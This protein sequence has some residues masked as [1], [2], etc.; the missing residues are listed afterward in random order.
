MREL[1]LAAELYGTATQVYFNYKTEQLTADDIANMK[2]AASAVSIPA[3]CDEITSGQLPDG[4]SKRTR[5]VLFEADNS[6]RQYFYFD[7]AN[8]SKY[9]FMLN[10]NV[11]TP[12]QNTTGD[13][14]Y[15]EQTNIASG[16][17]SR[18]YT[19]S[20]SDGVNTFQTRSSAL[21]YAYN[22]QENSP[23]PDMVNL[24]KLLYRY[25]QAAEAYFN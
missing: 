19:F 16:L 14:Y 3:V 11:V 25:S 20:V 8:L 9:T 4:I 15:V 22:R 21:S 5:T 6:L 1:A 13:A 10:G 24:S 7:T 18:E 23:S 17:L 2:A 12:T